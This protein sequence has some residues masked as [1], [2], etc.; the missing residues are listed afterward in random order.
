MKRVFALIAVLFV[1]F[2]GALYFFDE[3][4]GSRSTDPSAAKPR[5][6]ATGRARA[7]DPQYE[8]TP[9]YYTHDSDDPALQSPNDGDLEIHDAA[10]EVPLTAPSAEIGAPWTAEGSAA[11]TADDSGAATATD[12]PSAQSTRQR[13]P[14]SR[15]GSRA[16]R[17]TVSRDTASRE[18]AHAGRGEQRRPMSSRQTSGD[19]IEQNGTGAISEPSAEPSSQ[20]TAMPATPAL[21]NDS[22]FELGRDAA[23][24]AMSPACDAGCDGQDVGACP[25]TDAASASPAAS[26]YLED[27]NPYGQSHDVAHEG[28]PADM[29]QRLT[30]RTHAA[31]AAAEGRTHSASRIDDAHR[32]QNLTARRPA[33]GEAVVLQWITPTEMSVGQPAA[34]RLIVHNAA[35][36]AVDTVEVQAAMPEHLRI[37]QSSLAAHDVDGRIVWAMGQL[38]PGETKAI[39]LEV[40]ATNEGDFN[41]VASVTFSHT[42][43][44]RIQ[45]L[46]PQ[47]E[48]AIEGP[49]QV[50]TG[51]NANYAIVVSNVGTGRASAVMVST[52]LDG[53]L[54]SASGEKKSYSIGTLAAGE[55]RRIVV[56]A[57]AADVGT[58][59]IL[60]RAVAKGDLQDDAQLEVEAVC[61]R[62]ELGFAG[63]RLR[64]VDHEAA[65]TLRVHNPGR[66]AASNVQVVAQLPPGLKFEEADGGATCDAE[67][68]QVT[69]FVGNLEP[70]QACQFNLRLR[71]VEVGDQPITVNAVL[72]SG[73]SQ[74]TE[75]VTRVEGIADVVVEVID[76]QDPVELGGETV[77]E[78]RVTNRGSQPANQVQAA[79]RLSS[80]C[81]AIDTQGPTRG[82]IE[83]A[84]VVFAPIA[85]LAPGAVETYQVRVACSQVGQFGFRA[86]VRCQEQPRPAVEEELTRVYEE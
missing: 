55:T 54:H 17:A 80:G 56:N 36:A 86:F 73:S 16:S 12:S 47:L 10:E 53:A 45:A 46:R 42:C 41:P 14:Q 25:S 26:R 8:S 1:V 40:T 34:C 3:V 24:P 76:S 75:F 66:A 33:A 83:R 70:D 21:A 57:S 6:F 59:R 62:V 74:A 11:E 9:V 22:P 64:Y 79:A 65:Y 52:H 60:A 7:A 67:R 18:R 28:P 63:P 4:L 61:P 69:W 78:I 2:S 38:A 48:L 82:K 51:Q 19:S 30:E 43:E 84:Q 68:G 20:Y 49:Q 58:C 77:Y 27:A 13:A 44:A 81:E 71:A 15:F 37:E 35:K 85:S 29:A 31:R 39:D 32:G 50:L 5:W 72:E 23:E